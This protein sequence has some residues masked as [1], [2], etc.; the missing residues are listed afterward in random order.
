ME[1]TTHRFIPLIRFHNISPEDFLSKIYPFK[2]LLSEDL[3]RN[4]LTYHMAPNMKLNIDMQPPRKSKQKIDSVIIN[5]KHLAIFSSWIEKKNNS[6]YSVRNIP[7]NF[8]LIYRA[9]RDGNTLAKFH[10]KC[11]NKGA[12][13]VVAKLTNSE[14]IVGGYNPLQWD[15][16][17]TKTFP[18]NSFIFSFSNRT[19]LQTAKVSYSNCHQNSIQYYSDYGPMFGNKNLYKDSDDSIW[20]TSDYSISYYPTLNLPHRFNVDDYEVFQVIKVIRK[21]RKHL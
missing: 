8:N 1:R 6:H 21:Q 11:D 19:D 12:T 15:S 17:N 13:I 16:S 5:N 18:K 9:S 3:F 10:E 4:I 20:R 2:V 14:Q 7:Y